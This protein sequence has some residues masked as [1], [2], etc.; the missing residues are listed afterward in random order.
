MISLQYSNLSGISALLSGVQHSAHI[1]IFQNLSHLQ[2]FLVRHF[3][4][5]SLSFIIAVG[6]QRLATAGYCLCPE[7]A[8]TQRQKTS[9]RAEVEIS[10]GIIAPR[11]VKLL[12]RSKLQTLSFRALIERGVLHF[13]LGTESVWGEFQALK[14]KRR[15]TVQFCT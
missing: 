12:D 13:F 7:T 10:T 3:Y 6:F 9:S 4:S 11:R 5:C 8:V 15:Y 2:R 1:P 14:T